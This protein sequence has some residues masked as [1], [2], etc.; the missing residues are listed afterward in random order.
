MITCYDIDKINIDWFD[1]VD[2]S[3]LIKSF[4]VHNDTCYYDSGVQESAQPTVVPT[5]SPIESE[6]PTPGPTMTDSPTLSPISIDFTLCNQT[7]IFLSLNQTFYDIGDQQWIADCLYL[8]ATQTQQISIVC[9]CIGKFPKYMANFWLN[10]VLVDPYH[11]LTV[12]NM[13]HY[14]IYAQ[15]CG[16]TCT[17]RR[18]RRLLSEYELYQRR[19]AVADSTFKLVWSEEVC[20]GRFTPPDATP[21]PTKFPTGPP[22][23]FPTRQPT[24]PPDCT[25][26]V[27][28][29]PASDDCMC[30]SEYCNQGEFC[31]TANSACYSSRMCSATDGSMLQLISCVCGSSGELCDIDELDT[32]L[33]NETA[34][35]ACIQIDACTHVD[36]TVTNPNWCRCEQFNSTEYSACT[37]DQ[38][39]DGVKGW[40]SWN[41]TCGDLTGATPT[42]V[43]CSCGAAADICEEGEYCKSSAYP[44]SC[45]ATAP[46]PTSKPTSPPTAS[47]S[48]N[49]STAPSISP[50]NT[51]TTSPTNPPTLS[52]SP[53]P[54]KSP[55]TSPTIS[56]TMNPTRSPTPSPTTPSPTFCTDYAHW[57][58]ETEDATCPEGT[59]GSTNRGYGS[60]IACELEYQLRL[61]ESQAN[62]MYSK[63]TSWCIY[64]FNSV[65]INEWGGFIWRNEGCWE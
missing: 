22:T 51:P 20:E 10:C 16:S 50:T 21:E 8:L 3:N 41:P 19:R 25:D 46:M 2:C 27:G 5:A 43:E 28:L 45:T 17:S 59:W 39:C 24:S 36:G 64:D 31:I 11:G 18:R 26:D 56:P 29:I 55:T 12:W 49:P 65:R 32:F 61:E 63:C 1:D 7:H 15:S 13:C 9:G 40:C 53:I 44:Y 6:A 42:A 33:C 35:T 34:A 38:Y 60:M 62:Q 52:P 37:I 23:P 58:K 54:T 14:S 57:S 30:N 48:E 47:P 4:K